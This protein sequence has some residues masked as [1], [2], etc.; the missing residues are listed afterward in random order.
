MSDPL[1][2]GDDEANTPLEEEEREA[3]IPTHVTRRAELNELEQIGITDADRWAFSRKRR[4]IVDTAFLK[5]LHKVMFKDIW[6]WAG[7]FRTTPRNIGVDAYRIA[8]EVHNLVGDV[9]YWIDHETYPADEIAV[10]FHHRLVSIHAFPN[11]NGRHARLAADLLMVQLGQPRFSW[12]GGDLV[13]AA[14]LRSQYIQA[15]RAADE[16]DVTQLLAFAGS[17]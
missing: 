3:L 7:E 16:H 5:T 15:L 12:G 14:G 8:T 1:F 6:R 2:E 17:R 9:I 10:R 4:K 11:G 13:E